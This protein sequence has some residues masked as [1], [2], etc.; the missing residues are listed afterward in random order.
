MAKWMWFYRHVA[1]IPGNIAAGPRRDVHK[2]FDYQDLR[3]EAKTN[4]RR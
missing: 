2:A 1:L 4:Q 3:T